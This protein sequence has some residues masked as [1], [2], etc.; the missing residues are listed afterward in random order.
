MATWRGLFSIQDSILVG[1]MPMY[2]CINEHPAWTREDV[3]L[4]SDTVIFIHRKLLPPSTKLRQGNVFTSVCDSVH[5]G[6]SIQEGSLSRGVR[7]LCQRGVSVQGVS[8]QRG[9]L[10]KGVSVQRGGLCPDRGLCP[11]E[12]SVREIPIWLR[13]GSTHPTGMHSC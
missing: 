4:I 7:G 12:V 13:A 2:L 6:I 5:R 9:C 11:W 1:R 10:S 3:R 8:V